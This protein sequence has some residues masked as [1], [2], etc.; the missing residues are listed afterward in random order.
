M[1]SES[2]TQLEME[3][4]LKEAELDRLRRYNEMMRI[5]VS[6]VIRLSYLIR[7]YTPLNL[8]FNWNESIHMEVNK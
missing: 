7:V 2:V 5:H 4:N 3:Q 1:L 8:H 6:N